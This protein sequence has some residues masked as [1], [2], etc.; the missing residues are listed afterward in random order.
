MSTSADDVSRMFKSRKSAPRTGS[1]SSLSSS[2]SISSS[3]SSS[4]ST[5][6]LGP[7]YKG[8]VTHQTLHQ[9]YNPP[10]LGSEVGESFNWG[11]RKK[12]LKSAFPPKPESLS[13]MS[14]PNSFS[15]LSNPANSGGKNTIH[16]PAPILPSQPMMQ[17]QQQNGS[18]GNIAH[19]E[20]PAV[21]YL[22]PLNGTFERKAINVPCFPEVLRIGRQTNAKTVPTAANGYFDSKVLSRQHAEMWSDRSGKIWIRDVKSSNGTFVNGQRLS[23][24]NRDS[25]PHELRESDIL[26]L[27]IDIVSEDQKTVVHHKVAARV[28]HAGFHNNASGL[29]DVNFGDIDSMAGAGMMPSLSHGPNQARGRTNSQGSVGNSAR[30]APVPQHMAAQNIQINPLAHQRHMNIWLSPVT[31]EQIVK[32]L[33]TELRAAREQSLDL[34]RTEQFFDALLDKNGI[35]EQAKHLESR[36]HA[37]QLNGISPKSETKTRYAD[38]P[39]PPPQQPLPE[40][41]DAGREDSTDPPSQ[42][43]L[44]RTD[45]EKPKILSASPIK[46]ESQ[47]VS[48]V[49]ALA[50]ARREIESQ[51]ARMKDLEAMLKRERTARESAEQRARRLEGRSASQLQD[52]LPSGAAGDN[53]ES[54]PTRATS[55]LA[56]ENGAQDAL[57]SRTR[58]K[59]VSFAFESVQGGSADQAGPSTNSLQDR[60]ELMVTEMDEMKQTVENYKRRVEVAEHESASSRKTLAEMVERIRQED[61]DRGLSP[62]LGNGLSMASGVA[63]GSSPSVGRSD[64]SGTLLKRAG[65]QNGQT[66]VADEMSALDRVISAALSQPQGHGDRLAQSAPYISMVGVLVLGVGMMAIL[67]GWQKVDRQ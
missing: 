2:S 21:L 5:A 1:A 58:R 53:V 36:D 7:I 16:Q 45:T 42:P 65:L 8:P 35:R 25:E 49:E 20:A 13:V 63:V 18:R 24:E 30:M 66:T 33:S 54:D 12:A 17:T 15:V 32:T 60:L 41:P 52:D 23:L 62:S 37:P 44:T 56:H 27:G 55:V 67:N 14:T 11:S 9:N 47:V 3:S 19:N 38:P 46:G 40:K 43:V 31:M 51:G 59:S 64:R 39:A 22:L 26:E 28:E 6:S 10:S 34:N 61:A 57:E 50:S 29:L 4:S 48:L